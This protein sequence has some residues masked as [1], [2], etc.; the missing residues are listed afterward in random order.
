MAAAPAGLDQVKGAFAGVKAFWTKLAPKVK[1]LIIGGAVAVA[2]IAVIFTV[3]MNIN[4]SQYTVLF[5]GIT[6]EEAGDLYA[7]LQEE[8]V[9]AQMNNKSQVLVPTNQVESLIFKMQAKGFPKTAPPY[10]TYL[11]NVSLTTTESERRKIEVFQLQEEIKGTLKV[12]DGI[13]DAKVIIALPKTTGLVIEDTSDVPTASVMLTLEND[14][15]ISSD[16]VMTIK[17]LVAASIQGCKAENVVVTDSSNGIELDGGSTDGMGYALQIFDHERLLAKRA[18]DQVKMLWSPSYGVEGMRVSAS[19]TLDTDKMKQESREVKPE[20]DGKGVITKEE[21]HYVANGGIPAGGLV[22]EENNTDNPPDYVTDDAATKDNIESYDRIVDYETSYIM[23]Q[24]ERGTAPVKNASI[25]LLVNDTNLTAARQDEMAVLISRATGID[26]ANISIGLLTIPTP[27]EDVTKD[28]SVPFYQDTT[29]LMIVGAAMLMLCMLLIVIPILLSRKKKKKKALAMAAL[30]A[31]KRLNVESAE[32]AQ[33]E[34]DM[35]KNKLKF[36]A[37]AQKI[38][39]G[40]MTE[41]IR[42]FAK[43]NPEM[44]ATLIRSLLKDDG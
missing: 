4:S 30:E 33:A 16:N 18:E 24:I 38:Q 7:A 5:N 2:A 20:D 19:Y 43:E 41:E 37:E 11:T 26:V 40:S 39:D 15:A 29:F 25:T 35:H 28:T 6:T 8:G 31:E 13:K 44:T 21:E 10:D 17:K 32:K 1:K 12:V 22:G 23:T 14:N 34:I 42:S 9:K 27:N 3:S 36:E